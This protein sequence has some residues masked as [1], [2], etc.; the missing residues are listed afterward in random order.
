M[1]AAV[2][3]F[4]AILVTSVHKPLEHQPTLDSQLPGSLEALLAGQQHVV[5]HAVYDSS[6]SNSQCA[7]KMCEELDASF[8]PEPSGYNNKEFKLLKQ[9]LLWECKLS[10]CNPLCL[11]TAW[12]TEFKVGSCSDSGERP[13]GKPS[14]FC[15]R[16][17]P[18]V[19]RRSTQIALGAQIQAHACDTM[20]GCCKNPMNKPDDP[21]HWLPRWVEERLR[22]L[23]VLTCG[24]LVIKLSRSDRVF[25][26]TN[27]L[28]RIQDVRQPIS[29]C[30]TPNFRMR[31][32]CRSICKFY[33]QS[34]RCM[35]FNA[36][37]NCGM[38]LS[39]VNVTVL[40]PDFGD[41]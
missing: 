40:Q 2:F 8:F 20:L 23:G 19:E 34:T 33:S 28:S 1:L 41:A 17:K 29:Q 35:L 9:Q 37:R 31:T 13:D 5:N 25:S 36:H 16:F 12:G 10:L 3:H 24:F 30:G 21:L 39:A 4:L 14:K 27:I 11:H 7:K 32:L 6:F 18:Q 26:T 38:P 15:K 22:D